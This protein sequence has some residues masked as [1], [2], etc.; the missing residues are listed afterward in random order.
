MCSAK[1]TG[2]SS[3]IAWISS[4]LASYGFDGA[5][6]FSPG[7]WVNTGSR[8]WLCCAAARSPA[9]HIVRIVTGVTAFPPNMYRNFAAW[10]KI[11]SKQ[12][13]MKSMNM[14]S[15]T[16]RRPPVAAPTA[17]PMNADS[18]IGVSST[19]PGN[20]PYRPL[21][22]PSTPPHASS[23]PGEPAPPALSSPMTI[24]RSSRAIS[25]AIAS[26]IASR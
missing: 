19:R 10:L 17:A 13:P 15:T 11:W 20:F 25:W 1:I 24:T 7:T 12:T 22:T 26:L 21:V 16:G 3:R 23:S 8:L 2:S 18:E 4:P 14:S 6:T 5:A 9:P